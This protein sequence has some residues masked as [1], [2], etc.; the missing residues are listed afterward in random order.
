MVVASVPASVSEL[1]AVSVFDVVPPAIEK[2][3]EL[4]VSVKPLIVPKLVSVGDPEPVMVP[5]AVNA[6]SVKPVVVTVPLIAGAVSVLFVSA[7]DPV[8][9]VSVPLVGSETVVV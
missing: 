8:S 7:S 4:E 9:V 1:L 2:P 5:A 3:V 6:G